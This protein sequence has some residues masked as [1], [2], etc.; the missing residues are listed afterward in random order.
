MSRLAASGGTTARLNLTLLISLIIS[1]CDTQTLRRLSGKTSSQS[2]SWITRSRRSSFMLAINGAN[3][4]VKSNTSATFEVHI[5]RVNLSGITRSLSDTTFL[6]RF[7]GAKLTSPTSSC[8]SS[9]LE[10][11]RVP[12]ILT[13]FPSSVR[14]LG[15]SSP[16]NVNPLRLKPPRFNTMAISS[17]RW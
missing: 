13:L 17:A 11:H 15:G 7:L 9:G 4:P 1:M 6:P 10:Y 14:W 5:L 3:R 8:S 16:E 2:S 12:A